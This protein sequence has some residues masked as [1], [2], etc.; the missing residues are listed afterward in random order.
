MNTAD[1]VFCEF[2][3]Q[4][5]LPYPSQNMLDSKAPDELFCCNISWMVY[6]QI[7]KGRA[8]NSDYVDIDSGKTTF[9]VTDEEL[10]KAREKLSQRMKNTEVVMYMSS[11]VYGDKVL[12]SHL[13]TI[14]YRLSSEYCKKQ[15]WTL[16]RGSVTI[17]PEDLSLFIP[18]AQSYKE[19]KRL[20]GLA[21]KYY[22]DGTKFVTR[23]PDGTG[24]VFYPSGN[25]A[26]VTSTFHP[27]QLEYFIFQD[28]DWNAKILGVFRSNGHGTCYLQNGLI[29]IN[30]NPL[31]GLYFNIKGQ[32]VKQWLWR[33]YNYHVHAPP[34]RSINLE[35]N[36]NITIRLISR[37]QIYTT[38]KANN[39]SITFNMGAKLVLRDLEHFHTLESNNIPE[40]KY[41]KAMRQKIHTIL[42]QKH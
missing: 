20:L 35:L 11:V 12:F 10:S 29:W 36:S 23:F 18:S 22:R 8:D 3:N 28:M 7:L 31:R 21:E 1:I 40:E 27:G 13:K 6:Q 34:F 9:H 14:S 37:D 32:T 4:I 15:G 39:N 33:D 19:P 24:N 17:K 16:R 2:C 26:I 5:S 41:L 42:Q 30:V 38:F 25:I